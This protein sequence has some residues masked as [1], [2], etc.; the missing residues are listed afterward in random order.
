MIDIAQYRNRIGVFNNM[1]KRMKI[2]NQYDFV[3]N[4]FYNLKRRKSKLKKISIFL[5]IFLLVVT[6]ILVYKSAINIAQHQAV[7]NTPS[8]AFT[9]VGEP[10]NMKTQVWVEMLGN[11]YARYLYGNGKLPKGVRVYHLNIRSLQNKVGEI[12]KLVKEVNP[13]LFSLS[14]CELRQDSPNF[15]IENLKVP[16]YNLHLPKSWEAHGY[17]RVVLYSKKTFDCPRMEDLEDDHLQTI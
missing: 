6:S 10:G 4:K 2:R 13:H 17:A 15:N 1:S 11:F 14:E 9:I 7:N 5:R 8:A 12:K 3:E 16:G